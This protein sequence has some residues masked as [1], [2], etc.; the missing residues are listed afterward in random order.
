M[1]SGWIWA[2]DVR[3]VICSAL[4]ESRITGE[5]VRTVIEKWHREG[6]HHYTIALEEIAA[7]VQ[8]ELGEDGRC[9]DYLDQL[10]FSDDA[11]VA[12]RP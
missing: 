1:S 2:N 3:D 8:N 10:V 12:M 4:E 7:I 9:E 5:S 11:P 6:K